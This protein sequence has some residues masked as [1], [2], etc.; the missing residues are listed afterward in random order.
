MRTFI[1]LAVAASLSA[2]AVQAQVTVSGTVYDSLHSRPLAGAMVGVVGTSLSAMTDD[3]GRFTIANVPAGQRRFVAQHDVIDALGL[4]GITANANVTDGKDPVRL[5]VPSFDKLWSFACGRPASS[6][7]GFI[8]GSVRRGAK[9]FKKA[10][11]AVSW[12][13]LVSRG[14]AVAQNQK[15]L[16][17]DTDST[18]EYAIC[19]VPL[20][21][22]LTIKAI[23]D[24][25][26]S[27]TFD[28]DPIQADRVMRRDLKITAKKGVLVTGRVV[29]DSAN[30][31]LVQADVVIEDLNQT[32]KTNDRGEFGFEGVPAGSHVFRVR[33]V[34]FAEQSARI[35]VEDDDVRAPDIVVSKVTKL[36]STVVTAKAIPHDQAMEIFETTRKLGL[37]KFM[38]RL[39]LDSLQGRPLT[40]VIGQ[41]NG[42]QVIRTRDGH[43]LLLSKRGQQ[44][45]MGGSCRVATFVN[46]VIDRNFDLSDFQPDQIEA[47]AYYPGGASVPKEYS[48]LNTNCGVLTVITRR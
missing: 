1:R 17:V 16:E 27:G 42:L 48:I 6:D 2:T 19:G 4:S 9:P 33:R 47:I 14:V 22:P 38:T 46:G 43:Y 21:N 5:T 3:R 12:V 35:D 23:A 45:A 28:I 11:V 36:D 41:W 34:G 29:V 30:A 15:M 32:V 8:F 24:S 39:A 18:G 40:D 7:S 25:A 10:T 26:E 13:D 44:S 20:E 31:P 37:G